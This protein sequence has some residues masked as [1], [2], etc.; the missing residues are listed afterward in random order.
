MNDWKVYISKWGVGHYRGCDFPVTIAIPKWFEISRRN[1]HKTAVRVVYVL[2]STGVLVE[3]CV[4][5][6]VALQDVRQCNICYGLDDLWWHVS[7]GGGSSRI[8]LG[9]YTLVWDDREAGGAPK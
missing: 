2:H 4:L 6:C 1:R 5:Q 3:T 9:G 7:R 8:K